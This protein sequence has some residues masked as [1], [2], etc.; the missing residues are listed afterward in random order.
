VVDSKGNI[1][2]SF[3]FDSAE[4]EKMTPAQRALARPGV[5]GVAGGGRVWAAAIHPFRFELWDTAGLRLRIIKRVGAWA[6]AAPGE[7]STQPGRP[8]DPSPYEV[9]QEGHLLWVLVGIP[10]A[11]WRAPQE[12]SAI[13]DEY[14]EEVFDTRVEVIDLE[15]GELLASVVFTQRLFALMR[16]GLVASCSG[17]EA[18]NSLYTV[19]ELRLER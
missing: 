13:T 2:R 15:K 3:G 16:D 9:R 8:P 5:L 19:W 12:N 6:P 10:S 18:G 14:L 17:D 11:A 7:R 1:V 4:A